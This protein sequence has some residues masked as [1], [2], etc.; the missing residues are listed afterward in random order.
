MFLL[1]YGQSTVTNDKPIQFTQ[2]MSICVNLFAS[3]KPALL[4]KQHEQKFI[5]DNLTLLK[6]TEKR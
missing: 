6:S 5:D 2:K 3:G 4:S 1:S